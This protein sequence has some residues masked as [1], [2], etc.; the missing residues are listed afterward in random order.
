VTQSANY[1]FMAAFWSF[2]DKL[3]ILNH[4]SRFWGAVDDLQNAYGQIN[5]HHP[6]HG[7]LS[8]ETARELTD[9]Y[10]S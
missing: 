7:L 4:N 6:L 2:E 10:I 9:L 5:K 3:F 1:A 8:D